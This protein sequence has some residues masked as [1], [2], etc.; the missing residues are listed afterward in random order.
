MS[1][2]IS[3]CLADSRQDEVRKRMRKGLGQERQGGEMETFGDLRLE[4]R[5]V[6]CHEANLNSIESHSRISLQE[7]SHSP[8]P[9]YKNRIHIPAYTNNHRNT[10]RHYSIRHSS[11]RTYHVPHQP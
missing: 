2:S 4:D 8:H 5:K 6:E 1:A 10:H 11:D 9:F 3:F 7:K